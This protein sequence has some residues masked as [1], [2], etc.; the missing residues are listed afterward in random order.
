MDMKLHANTFLAFTDG[1]DD[2]EDG[3]QPGAGE[4]G[5]TNDGH[6]ASTGTVGGAATISVTDGD[7]PT[8]PPPEDTNGSFELDGFLLFM[9]LGVLLVGIGLVKWVKELRS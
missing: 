9:T 6:Q 2:E 4:S 3:Q 1:D 7:D 5:N 8:P